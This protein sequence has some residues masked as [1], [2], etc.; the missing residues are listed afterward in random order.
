MAGVGRARVAAAAACRVRVV[1][2]R[3]D[4]L[5]DVG[6]DL[7][8]GEA[9][10]AHDAADAGVI[11]DGDDELLELDL[12]RDHR[13]RRRLRRR[14]SLDGPTPLVRLGALERGDERVRQRGVVT[15]AAAGVVWVVVEDGRGG[16]GAGGGEA[17]EGDVE[18]ELE[19][20]A[21]ERVGVGLEAGGAEEAGG[22][23][24]GA[25][26]VERRDLRVAAPPRQR[27]RLPHH[28]RR[29]RRQRLLHRAAA[30]THL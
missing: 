19:G 29:L 20:L 16:G 8:A 9:G 14:L 13:R 11:E 17:V 27:H 23:E 1:Q 15:A 2:R 3:D 12:G 7:R 18:A 28:P 22:G 6:L 10:L 5:L 21:L 24:H 25:G 26:D 4:G 30:G